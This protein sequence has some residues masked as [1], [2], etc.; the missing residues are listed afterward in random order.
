VT[1]AKPKAL[2]CPNC[3]AGLEL[4]GFAHTLTIVCPQCQSVLDAKDPHFQI[5]QKVEARL[6]TRIRVPLGSRGEVRGAPFDVIGFQ[7]RTITVEGVAYSWTEYLLFNPYKGFLYLTEYHGHWNLART[8]RALPR[9]KHM[10]GRP[11]AFLQGQRFAHF[12][13]ADARTT[14]VAGE[15]PWRV[16]VGDR[17]EVIDFIA[18]PRML[19][20]E[21]AGDDVTWSLGEYVPGADLWRMF[22]LPGSPPRA[23]GV[24][25]NQP[26]PY[27]ARWGAHGRC[28]PIL[29]LACFAWQ[30]RSA[31]C[32][33]TRL[34]SSGNTRSIPET[35]NRSSRSRSS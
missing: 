30:W 27:K 25:A 29:C 13:T 10:G 16:T 15:F 12:Q 2:N 31:S 3:G 32:R 28:S 23:E 33:A 35:R 6:S 20:S 14:Y 11:A 4:R 8:L 19:S 24:Y 21:T 18:P 7:E 1:V 22:Q 34:P 17:A 26:S 5:I 9:R